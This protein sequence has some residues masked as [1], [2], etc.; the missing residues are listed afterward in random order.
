[1]YQAADHLVG[2]IVPLTSA[3]AEKKLYRIGLS[4]PRV[5]RSVILGG[6]TLINNYS[7]DLCAALLDMGLPMAAFGSG[8][9][10]G[11]HDQPADQDLVRWAPILN[12]FW[13]VGVRGPQSL[14]RLE[15]V[16][17]RN[18]RVV[19]D[20]ALAYARDAEESIDPSRRLFGINV[21]PPHGLASYDQNALDGI[22]YACARLVRDGWNPVPI[23]THPSDVEALRRMMDRGR[24][25]H[26]PIHL[27]RS[28]SELLSLLAP[29]RVML[30]MRLHASVFACCA[31]VPPVILGYGDKCVDFAESMGLLDY[32]HPITAI[33]QDVIARLVAQV[34]DGG[35]DLRRTVRQRA[36]AYRSELR[37][38][39]AQLRDA[40][41][42]KR[43]K[44]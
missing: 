23:A 18:V 2:G 29:C 44:T 24:L 10:S 1:M 41:S 40:C 21:V 26:V 16:G 11:G 37:H 31:G 35:E 39:A 28:A 8:A 12:R 43:A 5:F 27:P 32:H 20:L 19:G 6:G 25:P 9:G 33:D 3:G 15:S 34:V 17:V 4:G 14:R 13:F 36:A 7:Y 22:A 42:V 30:S 38:L